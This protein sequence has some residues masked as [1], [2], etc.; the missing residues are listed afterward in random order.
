MGATM[1]TLRELYLFVSIQKESD[2]PVTDE[3]L[4][5]FRRA[6]LWF[7]VVLTIYMDTDEEEGMSNDGITDKIGAGLANWWLTTSLYEGFM[8]RFFPKGFHSQE[9]LKA[10]KPKEA[11]RDKY[12][13]QKRIDKAEFVKDSVTGEIVKT[14]NELLLAYYKAEVL[15]AHVEIRKQLVKFKTVDPMVVAC[16][17]HATLLRN[18][19]AMN[20]FKRYQMPPLIKWILLPVLTYAY[21]FLI[22][23]VLLPRDAVWILEAPSDR[24]RLHAIDASHATVEAMALVVKT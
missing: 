22:F 20:K 14:K 11:E 1:T 18:F 24:T 16:N 21:T 3:Q 12:D 23:P 2:D 9:S 8:A 17:L 10:L 6:L 7:G 13:M 5:D 19:Q 15:K 4:G